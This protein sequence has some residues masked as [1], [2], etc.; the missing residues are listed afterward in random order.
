MFPLIFVAFFLSSMSMPRNVIAIDWFRTVASW[1]PISYMVEGLRSLVITGWDG[2]ALWRGF[3]AA[4]AIAVVAMYAASRGLRT[5][6]ER[7]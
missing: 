7:T 1:N 4:G 3:L 6:M 5:R 2:T